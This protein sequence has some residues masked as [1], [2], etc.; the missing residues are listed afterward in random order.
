VPGS[1][2]LGREVST[3]KLN[4]RKQGTKIALVL[5]PTWS[6]GEVKREK[7]GKGGKTAPGDR[8]EPRVMRGKGAPKKKMDGA[9]KNNKVKRN[10]LLV[11][12][13]KKG[14]KDKELRER[15]LERCHKGGSS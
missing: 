15:P 13:K 5:L 6:A 12:R 4:A 3:T 1:S 8:L 7:Q 2:L 11:S 14:D 10:R 9:K